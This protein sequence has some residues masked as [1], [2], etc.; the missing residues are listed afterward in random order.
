MDVTSPF[1]H[2]IAPAFHKSL[3]P[4]LVS[5]KR[6]STSHGPSQRHEHSIACARPSPS[7][8][9]VSCAILSSAMALAAHDTATATDAGPSVSFSLPAELQNQIFEIWAEEAIRESGR[10]YI[11]SCRSIAI[12]R[13]RRQMRREATPFYFS[14]TPVHLFLDRFRNRPSH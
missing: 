1:G 14:R 10:F 12:R 9:P 7:V 13:V 8:N 4:N 2:R 5:M 11:P 3:C 6:T